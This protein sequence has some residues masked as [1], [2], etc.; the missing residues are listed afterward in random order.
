M[1]TLRQRK[2]RYLV[3]NYLTHIEASEISRQYTMTQIRS[4]PYIQRLIRTRRLQGTNL[5]K[6]GYTASE[7]KRAIQTL[8]DKQGLDSQEPNDF[9]KIL[10][11]IRDQSIDRGEYTPPKRIGS[12]HGQGVSKGD[13]VGQRKR[14]SKLT[15]QEK[16]NNLNAQINI[17]TDPETKRW[18][19]GLRDN[20]KGKK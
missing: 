16:I 13:V 18:L 1:P 17:T 2:Y 19:I 12:H 7:I 11:K 20:L 4:L 8:Y 15:V 3:G 10:R 9:W 6:R 5:L 14:A